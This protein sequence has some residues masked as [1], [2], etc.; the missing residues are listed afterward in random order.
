VCVRRDRGNISVFIFL[1]AEINK[2]QSIARER[3]IGEFL[4]VDTN[5]VWTKVSK[6][7]GF[8]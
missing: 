1:K 4:F 8:L 2:E 5:N 6:S 3:V 7:K